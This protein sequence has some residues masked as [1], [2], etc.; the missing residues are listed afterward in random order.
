MRAGHPLDDADRAPWLDAVAAWIDGHAAG[1]VV[2]CSALKRAYRDRLRRGREGFR[3]VFL[4]GDE[5]L[6]KA[7]AADRPGH[8]WPA[9]LTASQFA[10]LEPPGPDE[11]P[12]TVEDAQPLDAILDAVVAKLA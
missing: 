2:A 1:C 7:R 8:Y 10:D 11:A 3:L 12:I 9:S 6:I 4:H 5:G